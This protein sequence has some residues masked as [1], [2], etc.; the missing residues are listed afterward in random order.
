MKK[1]FFLILLFFTSFTF[2]QSKTMVFTGIVN[3][4]IKG[5]PLE[6][7][8]VMAVKLNTNELLGF[9]RTKK[10]GSFKL[11]DVPIDT[12]RLVISHYDFDQKD[13]F[14]FGSST[15]TEINIPNIVLPKEQTKQL[16]EVIIYA[17]K[18]PIYFRGDTLVYT[19]D[20][21][22]TKEN[23]V[24][25]DLLK[26][27][28][29]ITVDDNGNITSQGREVSKVLVDGDEFFGSDPTIATRNLQAEGV[30][31][32]EIYETEDENSG[33]N[34]EDK[35]QVM[36][37]ELKDEYKDGYFGKLAGSGG[38]NT[39]YFKDLPN[40]SLFYEGQF[41]F[42]YFD[43]DFKISVFGMGSNT[44]NTGFSYQD[45][46][47][48]GLTN[49]M[50]GR[51][52]SFLNPDML[53][54]IPENYKGGFYYSDKFG[55]EKKWEMNL[56]YT[57]NDS[58]LTQNQTQ[59]SEYHFADSLYSQIDTSYN[60]QKKQSHTINFNLE[61]N[62]NDKTKLE[63]KSNFTLH[64]ETSESNN[65]SNYLDSHRNA[66]SANTVRNSSEANGLE[67][68]LELNF[69]K[70][71]AKRFRELEINYQFGYT[72]SDRDN[73]TDTKLQY[74]FGNFTLD[75]T[76]NQQRNLDNNTTGH[77]FLIDYTE[78][79]T[80]QF[81]LKFQ[82]RLDYFYGQQET[83][84]Y[85]FDPMSGTYD[86][87][88]SLFS[89]DFSNTRMENRG[90]AGIYFVTRKQTIEAGARLRNVVIDNFNNVSNENIN[91]NVTN[92]LPY[93]TYR[94]KFSN[95]ERL[96]LN[97]YTSSSQPSLDQLQPV[98]DNRNPNS[99]VV[100]NPNLTPDY[101]HSINLNYNR[102]N[103]L[104]RTYIFAGGYFNYT[105]NAFSNA[106]QYLPD[107]RHISKSINVDHSMYGGFYTGVGINV[108]KDFLHIRPRINGNY[109]SY[110]S[111]I[112]NQMN[113]T[114]NYRLDGGLELSIRNDTMEVSLSAD[115]GY[116]YPMSSLSMGLNEPYTVQRYKAK[117]FFELPFRFFIDSDI[118]Y[119]INSQRADG[120]NATPLIWN[121]KLSR[122]FTKTGNL[123]IHVDVYDIFNQNVGIQRYVGTNV[124]TDTRSQ[125]IARYFMLGAT[126]RFNNNKTK[127]DDKGGFFF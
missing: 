43:G 56:N 18:K 80:R 48:F 3:D 105:M 102:W 70:E 82:Y 54:G 78:P 40:G 39:E 67:G 121:A 59:N 106:I 64:D 51:W 94:L 47:R 85:D 25:E 116:N 120:Y 15:N 101:S 88:S 68:N 12:M 91:Q 34:T 27:L 4:T 73:I 111:M 46:S 10:D 103:M 38:F 11:T 66:F 126:W 57:Y 36:N 124:I 87:Y 108:F 49:E 107:G 79:I 119:V 23:A 5:K 109:T 45:A 112:N 63:L 33:G 113:N 62:I 2:S 123:V 6:G 122:R 83:S 69:E 13:Y 21:F 31:K 42:N 26:N 84:T 117:I 29:G 74:F 77:R 99:L 96:R 97:Y 125:V 24:V 81:R 110:N 14:I 41:L 115:V 9:T 61:Y 72:Q 93:L 52:R 60:Y 75:S 53:S 95:A 100:G 86:N 55:K 35:I 71:F 127:V 28:P 19:A 92:V 104:K 8:I 58:R 30:K 89:N 20:S 65:T 7:A 32:V 50:G 37:I 16:N 76:Y 1:L 90:S 44:P 118:E 22:A 98:Q 17:N 114:Q